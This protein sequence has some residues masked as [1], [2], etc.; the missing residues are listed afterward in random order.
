MAYFKLYI[1]IQTNTHMCVYVIDY[2]LIRY[3][4]AFY[5]F[6]K[7]VNIFERETFF[8]LITFFVRKF[9]AYTTKCP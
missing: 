1:V 3:A 2:S 5:F 7:R 4:Y 6:L 8:L 9:E